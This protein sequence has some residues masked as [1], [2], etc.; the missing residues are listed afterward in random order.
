MSA[1]YPQSLVEALRARRVVPFAGAGVSQAVRDAAGQALFPSWPGLLRDAAARLADENKP[2]DAAIVLAY[3]NKGR[4]EDAATAAKDALP[5][6]PDF[7]RKQFDPGHDENHT[8]LDLARAIWSLS[9]KLVITTN[10]DKVLHWACPKKSPNIIAPHSKAAFAALSRE[11]AETVWHLHGTIDDP[12]Q[13]VLDHASYAKLYGQQDAPLFMLRTHLVQRTLL[14]IGFEVEESV[15]HQIEW[16]IDKFGGAGGPHY[17]LVRRQ[18]RAAFE[19]RLASAK[20]E[21]VEFEEFNDL[22]GLVS[23][24]AA[25]KNSAGTT[26][27]QPSRVYDYAGYRAKARFTELW[28][29][30]GPAP[31]GQP[32]TIP[33]EEMYQELRLSADPNEEGEPLT[34][35]QVAALRGGRLVLEGPAGCGKTTWMKHVMARLLD[36]SPECFPIFLE[37][38][39]LPAGSLVESITAALKA[40]EL[41]VDGLADA[42]KAAHPRPVLL[43]DGWDELGG[44]A[45]TF[46][47]K[48]HT[49]LTD[50]GNV[51]AIVTTRPTATEK[52]STYDR[53]D[54]RFFQPLKPEEQKTFAGR[55]WQ[56]YYGGESD[57]ESSLRGFLEAWERSPDAQAL[58]GNPMQLSMMLVISRSEPLPDRRHRLYDRLFCHLLA[59]REKADRDEWRPDDEKERQKAVAAMAFRMQDERSGGDEAKGI[60]YQPSHLE[61]FLPPA[62]EKKENFLNWLVNQAGLLRDRSD[63]SL[64]FAHLSYQDFAAARHLMFEMSPEDAI[65]ER[66]KKDQCWELLR[67]WAGMAQDD[68]AK[69]LD[70]VI[71]K[72]PLPLQG[73]IFADGAGS[74]TRFESWVGSFAEACAQKFS[75]QESVCA[76]AL[77]ASQ[78][79]ERRKRVKTAFQ[80][81]AAV[82]TLFEWMRLETCASDAN[83]GVISPAPEIAPAIHALE[84]SRSRQAIALGRLW[85]FTN[86]TWP[87]EPWEVSLL[88]GWPSRRRS[89]SLFL[90]TLAV[91]GVCA[92]ELRGAASVALHSFAMPTG[93]FAPVFERDLARD[94]E[95]GLAREHERE[96]AQGF[97]REFVRGFARYLPLN[98]TRYLPAELTRDISRKSAQYRARA[99]A[100]LWAWNLMRDEAWELVRFWKLP[101][102][103]SSEDFAHI[104]LLGANA[105]TYRCTL[106]EAAKQNPN[107]PAPVRLLGTACRQSLDSA[108]GPLPTKG[109]TDPLWPALARHLS[110]QS[111]DADRALLIHLA[112]HPEERPEPLRWGL[113]YIAAGTIMLPG[114]EEIPFDEL[115]P[116]VPY[117]DEMEP[118]LEIDAEAAAA[119]SH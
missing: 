66:A 113:H 75:Y 8:G 50:H 73:A 6:W 17:V 26:V 80:A 102:S 19:K 47:Q 29:P 91:T 60:V 7:L 14:F 65:V 110:R 33:L 44:A 119:F 64:Q 74:A 18:N 20:L 27:R 57:H 51:T 107:L 115:T 40:R 118:E 98:F 2:D 48:L 97:A 117:L 45:E 55:F 43:V 108:P 82:G 112:Q 12:D 16:E 49:F 62:I 88:N 9:E 38:R 4:F 70:G 59:R 100:K 93:D 67:L 28:R 90:Q 36:D 42:L 30:A 81:R 32:K 22:P 1:R 109:I 56:K 54:R 58:G 25:V 94:F 41:P 84:D 114:G 39:S 92:A 95:R 10:Y 3:V 85:T 46:R 87:A 31:P 105:A 78:Q 96:L 61:R 76:V 13:I 77:K 53:F 11:H 68:Q 116:G 104:L 23:E 86:C 79:A 15:Q 5:G 83:L 89:L 34:P 37:L 103:E 69:S 24:L 63:G 71:P 101:E 111:T 21:F 99:W 72:L 106:A 35:A 52:P